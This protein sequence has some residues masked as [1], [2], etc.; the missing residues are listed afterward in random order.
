ML[1]AWNII[2]DYYVCYTNT[3]KKFKDKEV[4]VSLHIIFAIFL[5]TIL[6][7]N[8]LL[9]SVPYWMDFDVL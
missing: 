6:Y 3:K 1:Y 8:M 9:G 2:I 7:I 4:I 5:L